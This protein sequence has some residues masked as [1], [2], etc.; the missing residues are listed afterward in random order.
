MPPLFQIYLSLLSVCF[1]ICIIRYKLLNYPVKLMIW[2]LGISLAVELFN[3]LL[4]IEKS[5]FFGLVYHFYNPF[6]YVMLALIYGN[7]YQSV[8]AKKNVLNSIFPYL[9]FA[10]LGSAYLLLTNTKSTI[11]DDIHNFTVGSI[12]KAFMALYYFYELYND[13]SNS[14]PIHL[15][16]FWIS[17]GNLFLFTMSPLIMSLRETFQAYDKDLTD[18]LYKYLNF[19]PNYVMYLTYSVGL[20]CKPPHSTT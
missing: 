6:E 17:V 5:P 20:L 13:D 14:S 4:R 18:T 2:V 12:L 11:P 19:I 10:V 15:S 1:I 3:Y 8:P 7:S 9:L 16:M